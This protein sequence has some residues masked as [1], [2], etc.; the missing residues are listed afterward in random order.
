MG[1]WF[2]FF[3]LSEYRNTDRHIQVFLGYDDNDSF[4]GIPIT[5]DYQIVAFQF[6][7]FSESKS[8]Y[9]LTLFLKP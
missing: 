7:Q 9:Q 8:I 6:V 2:F 3:F 4:M 1:T 5:W